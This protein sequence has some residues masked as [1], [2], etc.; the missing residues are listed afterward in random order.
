MAYAS[1]LSPAAR[2]AAPTSAPRTPSLPPVPP[3]PPPAAS[4][5]PSASA[6]SFPLSASAAASTPWQRASDDFLLL[7]RRAAS[8][9]VAANVAAAVSVSD[10]S[11]VLSRL[12]CLLVCDARIYGF[13]TSK[14][15]TQLVRSWL[16]AVRVCCL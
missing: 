15:H 4:A 9:L 1:T 12:E 3:P 14:L 7:S 2:R 10:F 5:R 8:F 13:V 16:A 11:S 6:A